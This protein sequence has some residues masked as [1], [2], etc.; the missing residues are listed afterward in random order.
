[1]PEPQ[2]RAAQAARRDP[3]PGRAGPEPPNY[4]D[5]TGPAAPWA[6]AFPVADRPR[7]RASLPAASPHSPTRAGRSASQTLAALAVALGSSAASPDRTGQDRT[8]PDSAPSPSPP[9]PQAPLRGP[10]RR[11]FS[12]ASNR[13]R[14]PRAP[15][16][17]PL[18]PAPRPGSGYAGTRTHGPRR[19][20]RCPLPVRPGS[21]NSWRVPAGASQPLPAMLPL[22]S[23]C[24]PSPVR[25]SNLCFFVGFFFCLEGLPEPLWHCGGHRPPKRDPSS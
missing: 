18:R 4:A 14:P 11:L 15:R 10:D 9:K 6:R 17:A 8:G 20:A 23:H 21:E 22:G 3:R 13:H 19:R 16:P 2:G 1:M 25:L 5:S 7:P 24:A 12:S